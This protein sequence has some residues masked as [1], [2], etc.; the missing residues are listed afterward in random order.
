M[1]GGPPAPLP[2]P[3][4]N[5]IAAVVSER[6]DVAWAL[7]RLLGELGY[8]VP[9]AGSVSALTVGTLPPCDVVFVDASAAELLA[10]VRRHLSRSQAPLIVFASPEDIERSIAA[11]EAGADD[12]I[13]TNSTVAEIG[14]RVRAALRRR[15]RLT[16][17]AVILTGGSVVMDVGHRRVTVA[18]QPIALTALEFK[19]LAFFLMHPD[20]PLT[21]ERLLQEV[22]GYGTGSTATVTVTVRRLR[23]KIEAD[24]ADPMLIRTV[25]GVGYRFSPTP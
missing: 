25:W 19:L 9:P 14:A 22:W 23:E 15:G 7:G 11:L 2:V 4:Q 12:L 1:T 10:A 20:E 5:V 13:T 6:R 3:P 18:G 8:T 24:P 17:S 21:R 16:G